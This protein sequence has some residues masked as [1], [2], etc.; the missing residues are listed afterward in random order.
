[1]API[2]TRTQNCFSR[3]SRSAGLSIPGP[4]G[5]LI[6]ICRAVYLFVHYSALNVIPLQY[7]SLDCAS[8]RNPC[9][10]TAYLKHFLHFY[11]LLLDT[12]VY[13]ANI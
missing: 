8:H 5:T 3:V 12:F 9:K 10:F 1:M 11:T 4:A 7:G 2:G 6:I 13:A